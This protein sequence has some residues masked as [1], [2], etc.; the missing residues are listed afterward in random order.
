MKR[1]FDVALAGVGLIAL[2]PALLV[3]AVAVRLD[4]SGPAV[5]RQTRIGRHGR[6]FQILKFRS[7]RASQGGSAVTSAGDTRITRVGGVLRSTKLDEL[8][9]LWNVL[10]GEMS[11]VGPRPEVPHYV[12]LWT[13][14][15]RDAILSVRP[16]LTDPAS[17]RFRREEDLLAAQSDPETYYAEH[18]LPLKASMYAEYTRQQTFTGDLRI[19]ARTVR[20][21]VLH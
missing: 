12:D 8:P 4:S 5:F 1:S 2:S 3:I 21:V 14:E 15:Q 13:P 17:L 9:Q 16:G 7:M 19:L 6:P 10:R 18:V 20:S 11:L